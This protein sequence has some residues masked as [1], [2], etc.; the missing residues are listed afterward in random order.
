MIFNP[1]RRQEPLDHTELA[2]LLPAP[3]D[4]VLPDDRQRLLVD[5]LMNNVTQDDHP[6]RPAHPH[7]RL[8]VRLAAP[9]A[10]AAAL[11]GTALA[12]HQ[13]TPHTSSP[14]TATGRATA[15]GYPKHIST[16]AYTL[17]HGTHGAVTVTIRD[18]GADR[19][20]LTQL[21]HDLQRMGVDAR[22][23]QDDP[24]CP[25]DKGEDPELSHSTLK[26]IDFHHRNGAFTATINPAKIPSGTHLEI[27]FPQPPRDSAQ[28][29]S[30]A[31]SLRQGKAPDCRNMRLSE[32]PA[33]TATTAEEIVPD[34]HD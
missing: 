19:P 4:P 29:D 23:Y 14:V 5:F 9:V 22:V 24:T 26:T 34:Q 10:L 33:P 21:Q 20:D 32:I 12:I 18:A 16:V 30:L 7:R 11:G 3:G 17:N 25:V 6:A 27:V 13:T 15:G 1:W 28:K 2:R 8:A 31:F